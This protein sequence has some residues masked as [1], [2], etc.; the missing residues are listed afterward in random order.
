MDRLLRDLRYAVRMLRRRPTL[1]V[2]AVVCLGLGLGA[3]TV[4]FSFVDAVLLRALP[5]PEPE[6]VM[7]IWNQFLQRDLDKMPAS[8]EE[9]LDHRRDDRAFA[10]VAGVIPWSYNLTTRDGEPQNVV[11]GRASAALF[12]ILGS[13]A[14]LGRVYDEAEEASQARVAVLGHDL[15]QRRFAGGEGVVGTTLNL[16]GEP[17]T[18]VGVLP[19]DFRFALVEADLWVPFTPNPA[20]PRRVRG[21]RLVGRLADDVGPEQ[22]QAEVDRLARLWQ[23]QWPDAYPADSGWGIRLVP[24]QEELAGEVEPL[25][26]TQFAAVLLVLAIAC[27]NVAN[28]QL[29]RATERGKEIALRTS[30]GAGRG[31]LARQLLTESVLLALAGGALG[32]VLAFFGLR[33]LV[34][35]DP[36]QVGRLA[37][38]SLDGRVLLFALAASLATGVLFGLAPAWRAYRP[39]LVGS[40]KEGGKTSLGGGRQPLRTVLVVA[41]IALALTVLVA[42]GLMLRSFQRLSTADP[43]FRT[44]GLLTAQ[45]TASPRTYPRPD[46]LVDLQGRLL[47]RLEALPQVRRAAAASNLPLAPGLEG[48]PEVEGFEPGPGAVVPVVAYQMVSPG[49]FDTLGLEVVEGRGFA[50]ADGAEAPRVAVVDAE[51]ARR[52]WP[53]RTAIGRRVR[54]PLP[55]PP[56]EW[57]RVVGVVEDLRTEGLSQHAERRLY[58]PFAQQP[59]RQMAL[60]A[61]TAGAPL[62]AAGPLR[63]AAWSVDPELPLDPVQPMRAAVEEALARP[64]VSSLLFTLF[65]VVALLLASIGVYGVTAYSVAQRTREIGVR[66]ALG[67]RR[68]AVMGLVL[69]R[70]MGLAAA[71]LALGLAV[72]LALAKALEATLGELAYG[73]SATDV[74]TFVAV[75]LVLAAVALLACW[76]PARRATRVDPTEALRYE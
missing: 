70:G 62:D 47:E 36:G 60:V 39:D 37:E 53:D 48:S 18:V 28:L 75:P 34:A 55:V 27:A 32:V 43:G 33:V 6:R 25:L 35:L 68:G 29:A 1:T 56:G 40:L 38:V 24:I 30:L 54:I 17:Y 64:K 15:W 67:S 10:A 26:W 44:D 51:L 2:A 23:E 22:A 58:L 7:V 73:V 66:M 71:G 21:V 14:R 63:R 20:V 12:G 45:T 57:L 16:D 74:A 3:A 41:E 9:F 11:G 42:A 65:G 49:Y 59:S 46:M 61:R 76:L 4:V 72:T 13:E 31:T 8:G 50:D 52:W 69:G 5:Y 19:E